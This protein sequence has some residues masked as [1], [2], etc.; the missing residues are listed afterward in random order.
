MLDL[1][2]LEFRSPVWPPGCF[3]A[4][5]QLFP[6]LQE[7]EPGE[8]EGQGE[9]RPPVGLRAPPESLPRYLVPLPR[10]HEEV[11]FAQHRLLFHNFEEGVILQ[12]P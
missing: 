7:G 12:R 8:E 10:F 2:L 5:V 3:L 4:P 9:V 1:F 11:K 6:P